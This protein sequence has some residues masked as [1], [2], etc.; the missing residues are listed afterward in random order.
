M[1]GGG[2]AATGA[3][4]RG[5]CAADDF[6]GCD[7]RNRGVT[8]RCGRATKVVVADVGCNLLAARGRGGAGRIRRSA[9]GP[10]KTSPR[11]GRGDAAGRCGGAVRN[12]AGSGD[13][14]RT[15]WTNRSV[16]GRARDG[17]VGGRDRRCRRAKTQAALGCASSGG[18]Q[19]VGA[20]GFHAGP[21]GDGASVDPRACRSVFPVLWPPWR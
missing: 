21:L 10:H 6:V 13:S 15:R 7:S 1:Q 4:H 12:A 17:V 18:G 16:G 5:L 3:V 19:V 9:A 14:P 20:S 8:R 11:R 2:A